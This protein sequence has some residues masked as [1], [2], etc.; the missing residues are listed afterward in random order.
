MSIHGSFFAPDVINLLFTP[1]PHSLWHSSQIYACVVVPPDIFLT[2]WRGRGRGRLAACSASYWG[3]DSRG[4]SRV[5]AKINTA[6]RPGRRGG[7]TRPGQM[8]GPTE[9]GA[10][11]GV[12]GSRSGSRG[13]SRG[14]EGSREDRGIGGRLGTRR[15]GQREG[16][17][18]WE[19]GES[20]ERTGPAEDTVVRSVA[21][22]LPPGGGS[23][24]TDWQTLD[25]GVRITG[26]WISANSQKLKI[27]LTFTFPTFWCLF[28]SN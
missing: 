6:G 24:Q 2:L 21:R 20:R 5:T 12:A 7:T 17:V 14:T 25:V 19:S 1:I 23:S 16:R 22:V 26:E 9:V 27:N 10:A 8:V 13:R 3:Q 4:G 15:H 11:A 28:D 18:Q